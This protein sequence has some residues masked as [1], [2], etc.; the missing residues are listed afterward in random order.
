MRS[1]LNCLFT[2]LLSICS[3]AL[4]Q[5]DDSFFI[6]QIDSLDG[7]KPVAQQALKFPCPYYT[8]K[9]K[10]QLQFDNINNDI[11][12]AVE[13]GRKNIKVSLSKGVYHFK[14]NHILIGKG[15]YHDVSIMIEGRDAIVTSDVVYSMTDF[16]ISPWEEL[17]FA[18]K[19]IEVVDTVKKLCLIPFKNEIQEGEKPRYNKVQV[20]QWYKAPIYNVVRID[21]RGVFFTAT[22]I[23]YVNS[24]GRQGYTFNHDYLYSGKTP[25]FRLYNME[26]ERNCTSS[27]FVRL[28]SN[29]IKMFCVKGVKFNGNK[30][31][32]SLFEL[33]NVNS[34]HIVIRDCEFDAIRGGVIN[35]AN[36]SNV[37]LEKSTI[38]N[39]VGDEVS[40]TEGCKNVRVVKNIFE[41]CGN[42]LSN[43]M[44]IRCNESE[45][46]IADNIF[47]DFGYAAVAVGLWYGHQKRFETKGIIEHNEI[48]F[49]PSYAAIK[50]KYTLM[51]GGAIYV[52]TQ[53][54]DAIIRYNYIHDYVGMRSYSGIYC[55]DG[56][57][58]C[59][60]YGNVVLN[61]P[62]GCSITS[63]K[64]K[65]L[66]DSYQNNKNN[67]IANNIV[68]GSV[69]F[70]G[71]GT[72][73][74]HCVKGANVRLENH[75]KQQYPS[76]I[77]NLEIE[78]EDVM[79]NDWSFRDGVLD[80]PRKYKRISKKAGIRK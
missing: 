54:D 9:V 73:E 44:C 20:T 24:F 65:D 6:Q 35:C 48:Y 19:N 62:D 47:R 33:R 72:E 31:G 4:G 28:G 41:N 46:Y 42:G 68:D 21:Q 11:K 45:Y 13:S 7:I 80:V 34:S 49:T 61:T 38:R 70:E 43:T 32:A 30:G 77:A 63:R 23:K 27:T 67:L 10:N 71:Y 17:R 51:D 78:R 64:V 36:V 58:N 75:V 56:A 79:V 15:D 14:N 25:R 55:D 52:W 8:I 57:S 66:K 12:K 59:K 50:D 37:T 3:V 16:A 5:D 1:F 18:D 74:R 60:I 76:R 40:F 39:T 22:E 26:K 69:V 53:N 2:A 29:N